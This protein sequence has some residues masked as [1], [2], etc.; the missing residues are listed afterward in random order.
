MTPRESVGQLDCVAGFTTTDD[1]LILLRIY[2]AIKSTRRDINH[3]DH[4]RLRKLIRHF[5]LLLFLSSIYR[6]LIASGE[7]EDSY[8]V[9]LS[10]CLYFPL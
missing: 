10:V 1:I 6:G 4:C 3:D 2:V 8:F 5:M 7:S 9:Y